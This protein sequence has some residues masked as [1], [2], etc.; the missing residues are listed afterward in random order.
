MLVLTLR[1]NE[2]V[3]A[4][5]PDGRPVHITLVEVWGGKSTL[6]IDAPLDVKIARESLLT[7]QQQ[8]AVQRWRQDEA[9][10]RRID[11]RHERGEDH[12]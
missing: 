9:H 1:R 10:E 11:Q 7:D 4:F 2:S 12:V 3:Y 6:G 8:E 5:L